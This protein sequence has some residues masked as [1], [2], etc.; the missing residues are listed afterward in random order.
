MIVAT[1]LSIQV[2]AAVAHQLF[3]RLSPPGVSALRFSLAALILFAAVRPAIRGRDA[4]T[5]RAVGAYGLCLAALNL[6]FFEA[7]S[8]IPMGIAVTLGFVPPLVIALVSARRRLDLLW[9]ALGGAGVA[10]VSGI[11]RPRSL[12]GVVVAVAAGV[13][14]IGVAYAGRSLGQRTRRADGLALAL[15][16]AA[17]ITLPFGVSHAGQINPGMI[18]LGLVIAVGGLIVPFTLEL[19]GL[20]RLTPATV[21]VIYSVDPANAAIIGLLALGQRMTGLQV[22]GMLAVVIASAGVTLG[23]DA[24]GAPTGDGLLAP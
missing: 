5:W 22:A 16:I 11:A 23:A 18:G 10:T 15:P 19:E 21:A 7:I 13:A 17:L 4:A 1:S 3:S 14:W 9:V 2:A 8:L 12:L 6:T 20:R 24:A